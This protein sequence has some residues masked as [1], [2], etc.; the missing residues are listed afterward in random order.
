[1]LECDP[2]EF[3]IDLAL[4]P[5]MTFTCS[6]T[7]LIQN[8]LTV[9][10]EWKPLNAIDA[11]VRVHVLVIPGNG[12]Q[13]VAFSGY[14]LEKGDISS[15]IEASEPGASSSMA[16]TSI[17]IKAI[18]SDDG[19]SFDEILDKAKDVPHIQEIIAVGLAILLAL[20]LAM[21][22]RR[23]AR[24]KKAERRR[25]LQQRM[26]S[27]FVMDEHDRPGRFPPN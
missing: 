19:D 20:F 10:M 6:V 4:D 13:S 18:N 2:S 26:A 12:T 24:K 1:M 25:H 27:A 14:M 5:S 22:A 23:N 15:V 11:G 16:F 21:N 17:Q 3:K 8:D 9:R 7:N